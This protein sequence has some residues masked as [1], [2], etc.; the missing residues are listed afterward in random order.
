M[1]KFQ[2]QWL[3][4]NG[5]ARK[6]VAVAET[7]DEMYQKYAPK[8]G[9][10]TIVKE[11]NVNADEQRV[12]DVFFDSVIEEY[13]G[14]C[15]VCHERLIKFMDECPMCEQKVKWGNCHEDM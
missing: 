6:V 7:A 11:L 9:K 10:F 14:R 15:P 2:V 3:T 5:R 1:K 8:D 13:V 4:E 12:T